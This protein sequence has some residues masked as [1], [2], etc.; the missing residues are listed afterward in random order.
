[1]QPP[2]SST[3]KDWKSYTTGPANGGR[4]EKI[5]LML[6]GVGSNG[7]DLIGL[8]PYLMQAVPNAIFISPD[9]PQAYDMIPPGYDMAGR[10]WFSLRSY[11]PAF[12]LAG[13]KETLPNL[14][15]YIDALLDQ[16]GLDD[17]DLVMMGFSQGTMMSLYTAPHRRKPIAG[18]LGY[19]GALLGV[20]ELNDAGVHK[21]PVCLIHGEADDVVPVARYHA[22][23]EALQESGFDVDG[24]S[25]PGLTHSIDNSGIQKGAA[26]LKRVL[27]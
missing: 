16:F 6:H 5:V 12:M 1:M 8:A 21:I 7:E 22:A 20:D 11:E 14:N 26:F 3:K 27:S 18:V 25:V 15:G 2:M 4:P 13:I 17:S 9:A 10:Q 19:S 23:L 24:L